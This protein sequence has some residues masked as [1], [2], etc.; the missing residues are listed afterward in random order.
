MRFS[1]AVPLQRIV[2][3]KHVIDFEAFMNEVRAA[4]DAG[5][6]SVVLG[7]RRIGNTAYTTSPHILSAAALAMTTRIKLTISVVVLP[8]RNPISVMQDATVLNALFPGR[9]RLGVGA[10]YN[11]HAFSTMGV[12]LADRSQLMEDGLKML[13]DF[14]DGKLQVD[15]GRGPVPI[16]DPALGE[17]RPEVWVGAWGKKAVRRTARLAD[18]WMPDPMRTVTVV[19]DLAEEYRAQCAELGKRPRIAVL[20]EAFLAETDDEA[21][22]TFGPHVVEATRQYFPRMKG[23]WRDA[24]GSTGKPWDVKV[25]PFLQTIDSPDQIRIEHLMR[26][27]FLVG[28]KDTWI[29]KLTAWKEILDFEEIV[30][31]SRFQYGPE[32]EATL[33][34]IR[35]VGADI[36]PR[37]RE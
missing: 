16:R 7:E 23:G 3:G 6:Y 25:D 18:G 10:G 8:L 22:A 9:F 28:S 30:L 31:R 27:R 14:R 2:D 26:D 12:D 5:F 29:D 32:P 34:S 24:S 4:E 1:L 21:A 35:R 13:N 37:F 36:I 15:V 11:E 19:K 17:S 33:E 20:R